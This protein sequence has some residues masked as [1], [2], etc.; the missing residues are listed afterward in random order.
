MQNERLQV[1]Y[2]GRQIQ[3]S[4]SIRRR[5]EHLIVLL[6]GFG[7][8]KECFS[9]LFDGSALDEYSLLALDLPGHGDS[10]WLSDSSLYSLQVFADVVNLAVDKFAPNFVSFVGHSMGGA[11]S[12]IASQARDD[13]CGVVDADGN[14]V[15]E[16]CGIVSRATASQTLARFV[17]KGYCEFLENLQE[18]RLPDELAWAQWYAKADPVAL[19][20][21][22]RSLVEW[23]DSGKLLSL[24]KSQRK[25]RYLYGERDPKDY[26]LP[27]L[28]GIDVHAIASSGHFMMI[29]NPI[30]FLHEVTDFFSGNL[31]GRR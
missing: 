17:E 14:L 31:V 8:A 5:G 22:A 21:L 13:I 30:A 9:R 23:S 10:S 3:L 15:A 27:D 20:E 19:H 12:L 2:Y 16:D 7:C 26:I 4:S 28:E 29:D 6:H 1:D 25:V 18:S 11:I 24:L